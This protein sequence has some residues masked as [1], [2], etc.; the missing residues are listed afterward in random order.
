MFTPSHTQPV[1]VAERPGEKASVTAQRT[2][3]VFLVG[4]RWNVAMLANTLTS[5]TRLRQEDGSFKLLGN[6]LKNT[7]MLSE[8]IVMTALMYEVVFD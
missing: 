5:T 3:S 8:F 4:S 6:T 1:V 7:S 2:P